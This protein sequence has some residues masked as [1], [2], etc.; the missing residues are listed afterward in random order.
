MTWS[1]EKIAVEREEEEEE[2]TAR[3]DSM[4]LA[5]ERENR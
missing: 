3:D 4:T 2:D 5:F 1:R